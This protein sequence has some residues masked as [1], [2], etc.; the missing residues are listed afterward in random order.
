[1]KEAN[2]KRFKDKNKYKHLTTVNKISLRAATLA[3]PSP[4]STS[5]QMSASS[6]LRSNCHDRPR[7]NDVTRP[8]NVPGQPISAGVLITAQYEFKATTYMCH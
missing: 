6:L 1:M 5:L 4:S 7:Y 3:C 8:E 2:I